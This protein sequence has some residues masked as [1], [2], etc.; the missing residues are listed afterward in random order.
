MKDMLIEQLQKAEKLLVES[1]QQQME[2][3]FRVFQLKQELFIMERIQKLG[4]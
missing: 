2:I 1:Q 4:H 3:M